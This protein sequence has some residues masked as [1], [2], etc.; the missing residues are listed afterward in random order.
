ML[1]VPRAIDPLWQ[2]LCPAWAQVTTRSAKRY[3]Q[4][5]TSGRSKHFRPSTTNHVARHFSTHADHQEKTGPSPPNT[6]TDSTTPKI[7]RYDPGFI[8]EGG[9]RGNHYIE[10]SPASAIEQTQK[11]G[12]LKYYPSTYHGSATENDPLSKTHSAQRPLSKPTFDDQ[13]RPL[14][15]TYASAKGFSASERMGRMWRTWRE[16]PTV[17]GWLPEQRQ[18]STV[19]GDASS[20]FLGECTPMTEE[21][22]YQRL[23]GEAIAGST[24]RVRWIVERLITKFK[25]RPSLTLYNAL[26]LSNTNA[27]WGAAWRVSDLLEEMETEGLQPDSAT[28]HAILKVTSVHLDHLLRADT[29]AYMHEKWISLSPDAEH[30]VAAG[31]FREGLLEQASD[32][33]ERIR[34]NHIHIKHWLLDLAVYALCNADEIDEAHRIMLWRV[35]DPKPEVDSILWATFLDK[36]SQARNHKATLW[37]WN[38]RVST[39]KTTLSSGAC[40]N[41]LATAARA[42]DAVLGTEV[43]AHLSSRGTP[44][45]RI[46]FELLVATYLAA[47]PPDLQRALNILSI[48]TIEKLE[49]GAAETRPLYNYLRDKPAQLQEAYE[50]LREMHQN[51]QKISIAL[52]N[53]LIECNIVQG[54]FEQAMNI[55]KTIHTFTQ[56][57]KPMQKSF[58][59]VD[60]FNLLLKGCRLAKSPDVESA[61]FLISE[62]QILGV[63]P[64]A[65]TYDRL[66]LTLL[67]ACPSIYEGDTAINVAAL[68]T[69]TQYLEWAFRHFVDMRS[70]GHQPRFGT[71]EKLASKFAEVGDARCWDI[72]QAAM[73]TAEDIEG[74]EK[75]QRFLKNAINQGWKTSQRFADEIAAAKCAIAAL[76]PPSAADDSS[77][78]EQ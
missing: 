35:N 25:A 38:R 18:W 1:P 46:H 48:M 10:L 50:T 76:K 71:V 51:G 34:R 3:L 68:A 72:L 56:I 23:E 63:V 49:P 67:G 60:T 77:V 33:L 20:F 15:T 62:M 70:D 4:A 36:A 31:L 74:L 24:P 43:F 78:Q 57:G 27:H 22:L 2:C 65:L 13:F 28:C 29:L 42:G 52:L 39:G 45:Q 54:N 7:A 75:K 58:A 73:D 47:N 66:I 55:Y 44:Y 19:E 6:D 21:Q 41:V 30:D 11:N 32:R 9:K 64:N 37:A 53:V 17:H 26:I 14:V 5:A 12:L 16:K 69:T 8:R 40:L 61:A 59:N